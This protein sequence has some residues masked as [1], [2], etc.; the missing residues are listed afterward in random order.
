M[1]SQQKQK[2]RDNAELLLMALRG[3]EMKRAEITAQIDAIRQQLA[4]RARGGDAPASPSVRRKLT[5]TGLAR[6]A[7][8]QRKRW[9]EFRRRR[10]AEAK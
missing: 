8:A 1:T 2:T 4:G 10:K 9:A 3:Y 6:I 5:A 7:A